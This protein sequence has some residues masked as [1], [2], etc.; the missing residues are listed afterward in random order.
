MKWF[1]IPKE[2]SSK[3]ET[4]R[5]Y[6]DW[7]E[8]LSIEGKEQ[9]VYCAININSFGGIRNFHVEHYRPKVKDKFPELEHEYSNL[10]FACAICNGFKSDDWKN[11]P[12]ENFD[13]DS[14]PDPS[15]VDYSD[16]LFINPLDLV[17]SNLITGKYIIQK[18]FLNRP[19][20]ILE[21]KRFH[22]HQK[23][24]EET[25]NFKDIFIE[26]K[27]QNIQIPSEFA[28]KFI[29]I[30]DLLIEEKHINPYTQEQIRR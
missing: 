9:C 19:Q 23:L 10:F 1:R 28:I 29:E 15:K 30:I 3:P 16:F 7:K 8:P 6:S 17:E 18:L 22:L 2:S 5:Y 12:S 4:G 11:E 26:L 13:N 24:I 21:R 14:Y 27:T 20:L 25:Q